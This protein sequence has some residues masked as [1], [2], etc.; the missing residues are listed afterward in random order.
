MSIG[1][2]LVKNKRAHYSTFVYGHEAQ[3]LKHTIEMDEDTYLNPHNLALPL[4][5]RLD[6]LKAYML[7]RAY[8]R[9]KYRCLIQQNLDQTKYLA[10]LVKKTA[11]LE[12]VSP[13]ESNIVCFRY[14]PGGLGSMELEKLNKTILNE[15]WVENPFIISDTTI[16]DGYTL[17]AC[18]VN[19]RST[20]ED[21]DFLVAEVQKIGDHLSK[22]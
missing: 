1:C 13:V 20:Y 21:F 9:D 18:N 14:Q 2:T 12:I 5:R 10:E 17:R 8:G 19:H 22:L 3:Y 11:R 4:S 7:L 15:L 16:K 6:C